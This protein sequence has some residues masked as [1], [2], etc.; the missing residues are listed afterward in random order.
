[1]IL[2]RDAAEKTVSG[3]K[4][5]RTWLSEAQEQYSLLAGAALLCSF[6]RSFASAV[7]LL[8]PQPKYSLFSG[9]S[10]REI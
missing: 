8:T 9:L 4:A 10:W 6:G 7:A 3:S 5:S 2:L 1:M